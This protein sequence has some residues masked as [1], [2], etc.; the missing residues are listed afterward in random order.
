MAKFLNPSLPSKTLWK[1]LRAIGAAGDKLDTGPII[2]SPDE[3]NTFYSL[4]V[5]VD[6]PGPSIPS[7]ISNE[8]DLFAFRTVPFSDVKRAI[9]LIKSNAVGLDGIPLKFVKLFLLLILSPLAHL[10]NESIA[11]KT[12]RMLGK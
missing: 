2:F 12:F 8:S 9:R 7:S 5:D 10:F 6:L 11:S 4:D 1:N 3:L